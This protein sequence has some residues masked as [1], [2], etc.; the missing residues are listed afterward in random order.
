MRQDPDIMLV[1]EI[2]DGET[3][4]ISVN[5]AL[6]GHL[7]FSTLHANTAAT[8]VPRLLEMGIESFL[9]ASTLEVIIGQRLLRRVC[10]KCRYS[11]SVKGEE[12][13]KEH[14]SVK[15]YF[16]KD[17]VYRLFKGKGCSSCN[18]NGYSG[19]TG[20]HELLVVTPQLEELIVKQA[21]SH[22]ISH[23]AR[24]QGMKLMF[25]DGLEKARQGFTTVSELLRV[26]SPPTE[27][28]EA[29]LLEKK[30]DTKT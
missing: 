12:I 27:V 6:T 7:L 22:D 29:D 26:A 19:R 15:D 17:E 24:R 13:L 8:A 10:P 16:K 4:E 3:A 20:I 14:P 28:I 25:E 23:L 2:R 21:S 9:L 11:Y 30:A 1:G 5:A 18:G